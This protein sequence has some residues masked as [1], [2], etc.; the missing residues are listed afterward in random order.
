MLNNFWLSVAFVALLGVGPSREIDV[1]IIVGEF[2]VPLGV[3]YHFSDALGKLPAPGHLPV[4]DAHDREHGA[5]TYC[6]S[7]RSPRGS[8]RLELFD[9]DFGL[10][11]ARISRVVADDSVCSAL[12]SEPRFAVAE[13]EYSLTSES[14]SAP[15]DF[16]FKDEG[17]TKTFE[18][19]WTY[20]DASRPHRGGACYS[21]GVYV[22]MKHDRDGTQSVTVQNWEEPGC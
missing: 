21:R 22:R 9:S 18:D 6:Y 3:Q 19:E 13:K 2:R 11:T 8:S 12:K 20:T 16:V 5:K 14:W 10:H 4:E 15:L 17:N 1:A 7:F